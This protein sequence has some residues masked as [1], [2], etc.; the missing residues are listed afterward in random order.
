M[1]SLEHLDNNATKLPLEI[2]AAKSQLPSLTCEHLLSICQQQKSQHGYGHS[3]NARPGT[4][5]W[6]RWIFK[7]ENFEKGQNLL[8]RFNTSSSGRTV[9]HNILVA[10]CR[11]GF[12]MVSSTE[13]S[14]S[15]VWWRWIQCVLI[16]LTL[17]YITVMCNDITKRRSFKMISNISHDI[18]NFFGQHR[19]LL[20]RKQHLEC[21]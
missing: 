4:T 7:V 21:F 14:T 6:K 10:L 5:L 18:S 1:P 19:L 11:K 12:S 2:F 20:F 16:Y 9:E 15:T 8:P 3:K 13:A 17:L